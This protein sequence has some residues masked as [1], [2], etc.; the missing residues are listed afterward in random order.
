MSYHAPPIDGTAISRGCDVLNS[1][2]AYQ[3]PVNSLA[4][5]TT[6]SESQ[7]ISHTKPPSFLLLFVQVFHQL[8]HSRFYDSRQASPRPAM[9]S[10]HKLSC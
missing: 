9:M 6:E 2:G 4:T 1:I 3:Q 5:S 10:Q 7:T 8:T